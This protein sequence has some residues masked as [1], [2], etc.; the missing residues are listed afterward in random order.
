MLKKTPAIG[1]RAV[2]KTYAARDGGSVLALAP[3]DLDILDGEFVC[4]V[5]PSGCGKSTLLRMLAGILPPSGGTLSLYDRPITGPRADIG[6][7]FQTPLLLPWRTIIGNVMLPV[8]LQGLDRSRYRREAERLLGVVGLGDFASRYPSELSGG[9]QQRAG[10]CRALVHDPKLLLMDEPFGAL[11]AMTRETLNLELQRIWETSHKTIVF[12]THS[13]LEAVFLADRVVVIT[14]RPGRI[15]DI[16][17]VG[18]ARPRRPS[19]ISTAEFGSLA[20][21]IR[22]HFEVQGGVGL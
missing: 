20:E 21:R 9:M 3:L 7:V 8:D 13:I 14:P 16:V 15:R 1:L 17:D 4:V 12:I 19:V 18:L 22:S 5:G 11:D 6:V 2:H 10:I